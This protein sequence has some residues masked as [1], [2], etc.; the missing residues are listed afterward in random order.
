MK[1]T[2]AP[3]SQTRDLN[4]S[5]SFMYIPGPPFTRICAPSVLL[6]P[7]HSPPRPR[8]PPGMPATPGLDKLARLLHLPAHL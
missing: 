4:Q 5:R 2:E 8:P 1:G 7:A 3:E 6:D